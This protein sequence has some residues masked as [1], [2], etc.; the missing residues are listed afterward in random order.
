MAGP[1]YDN[2]L[3]QIAA[4][5]PEG[6][7]AWLAHVLGL[8]AVTLE[9]SAMPSELPTAPRYADLVWLIRAAAEQAILHIELQLEPD[10][11]M[12]ERLL[13]Y[14]ARLIEKYHLPVISVVIWLKKTSNLPTSPAVWSWRGQE[15]IR[16]VFQTIKLWELPQE[17]ILHMPYPHL[18]PIAGLMARTTGESV[19]HIGQQIANA[20][21]E[22]QVKSELIGFLSLLAGIQLKAKTIRA[23]FRRHPMINELWK[24]SSIAQELF[25]EGREEGRKE[26]EL[27]MAQIALE[28]R[29]GKLDETLLQAL[30]QVDTTTLEDLVADTTLTIEQLKARI[31]FH[32]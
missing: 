14:Q 10:E 28:R 15:I 25:A 18:W 27:R 3:K 20:S 29:L 21:I 5:A 22:E 30:G 11:T 32:Q 23:A 31:G 9:N 24:H 8:G 1:N 7:F 16:C 4:E 2:V 13:G 19:V 17:D 6:L 26:G 12:Y